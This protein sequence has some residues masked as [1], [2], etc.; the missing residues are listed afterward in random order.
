VT[1]N[2]GTA[3]WL[4]VFDDT[5]LAQSAVGRFTNKACDLVVDGNSHRA[6]L[7][8]RIAHGRAE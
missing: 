1:S 4:A 7:E 6:R 5:L 2:R 8:P 3:A